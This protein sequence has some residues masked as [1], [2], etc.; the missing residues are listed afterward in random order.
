MLRRTSSPRFSARSQISPEGLS[1]GS[2]RKVDFA[3][4]WPRNAATRFLRFLLVDFL[5]GVVL[6]ESAV[7]F[8][9]PANAGALTQS[10]AMTQRAIRRIDVETR[11]IQ[12]PISTNHLQ[13]RPNTLRYLNDCSGSWYSKC[14]RRPERIAV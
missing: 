11:S 1:S 9:A 8:S 14:R 3:A 4:L 7:A 2:I 10:A 12:R 5:A 13:N 6:A